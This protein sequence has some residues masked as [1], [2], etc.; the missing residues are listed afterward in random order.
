MNP[1]RR[2]IRT[3][4]ALAATAAVFVL[5]AATTQATAAPTTANVLE[6]PKPKPKKTDGGCTKGGFNTK[7]TE[8]GGRKVT[9]TISCNHTGDTPAV[10]TVVE[11]RTP[12]TRPSFPPIPPKGLTDAQ[13]AR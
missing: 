10:T 7:T 13:S 8:A 3:L 2:L 5:P 9:T 11:R 6:K 4:P 12:P 1:T